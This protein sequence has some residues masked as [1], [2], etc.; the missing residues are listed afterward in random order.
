MAAQRKRL[1]ALQCKLAYERLIETKELATLTSTD[2][3]VKK[4]FYVRAK[5]IY[6]HYDEFRKAQEAV[7]EVI[8]TEEEFTEALAT[9]K[10]ADAAFYLSQSTFETLFPQYNISTKSEN[11]SQSSAETAV[12]RRRAVKLPDLHLPTFDGNL[13][14]WIA[15]LDM[16]NSS[17]HNDTFLTGAEKFQYLISSLSGTPLNLVNTLSITNDNYTI[18]YSMLVNR[19]N[20]KRALATE[21]L[22]AIRNAPSAVND[23]VQSLQSLIDTFSRNLAALKSLEFNV[24]QWDFL[25]FNIL[26][27]KLDMETKKSFE[28]SVATTEFPTYTELMKFLQENCSALASLTL[29]N[30]KVSH[31]NKPTAQLKSIKTHAATVSIK[32]CALCKEQHLLH[33][34]PRFLKLG[35]KERYQ[36]IKDLKLCVNCFNKNHILRDCSSK[37]NCRYCNQRHHSMLHFNSLYATTDNKEPTPGTSTTVLTNHSVNSQVLLATAIV[38]VEDASGKL[39]SCRC[40]LDS[41][42]QSNFVAESFVHK[43]NLSPVALQLAV[44]GIS[45][46]ALRVSNKVD[47]TLHS[48]YLN[49]QYNLQCLVLRTITSNLP[50]VS[51]N[52]EHIVIP[53]DVELADNKFN[54][55][56]KIDLLIG[57]P[58]FWEIMLSNKQLAGKSGPVLQETKLGWILSGFVPL[59]SIAHSVVSFHTISLAVSS[60]TEEIEYTHCDQELSN[61]T[62]VRFWQVEEPTLKNNSTLSIEEREAEVHFQNTV[63]RNSSGRFIVTIPF[64]PS[65]NQ[66]GNSQALARRRFFYLE[67]KLAKSNS[68]KQQYVDFM[69]EYIAL[70]HMSEVIDNNAL[71]SYYIPHHAVVKDS[72]STKLRVVFDASMK[73]DSGIS[74]NNAQLVGPVVQSDLLS[75]LLRFRTYS[76]V[77]TADIKMMYRQVLVVDNQRQYQRIF[78][79]ADPKEEL[80]TYQLNTVTYGTASGPFLATRCLKQ[81]ALDI[82]NSEPQVARVISKDFYV[83]DVLTGANSIEELIAIRKRVSEV[84]TSA[85]LDLRKF[86]SNN[87]QVLGDICESDTDLRTLEFNEHENCKTLG[88]IWNS[89]TDYIQYK[90]NDSNMMAA[91]P[92]KRSILSVISAIFDPLGLI[93]PVIVKAKLLIQALWQLQLGWDDVIPDSLQLDWLE[94]RNHLVHLN[95]IS[96]PRQAVLQNSISIELHGFCDASMA[97]YGS[98]IYLRATDDL[99]NISTRLL[100]AKSKVAPLKRITLP[101]LELCGAHLLVNLTTTVKQS[102]P[103]TQFSKFFYWCDSTIALAWIKSAPNRW[104]TFVC[105]R[106]ADIQDKTDISSW[107]HV[108]S[109]LNPADIVSRGIVPQALKNSTLWWSGPSFLSNPTVEIPVVDLDVINAP[110]AAKT[111]SMLCAAVVSVD[112]TKFEIFNR[113]SKY[114]TLV[115]VVAYALRWKNRVLN[116][117]EYKSQQLDTE[118]VEAARKSLIKLAQSQSFAEDIQCLSN[119]SQ[120]HAKSKILSLNPFLDDDKILR[121]GG[122]LRHSKLPFDTKHP[123]LICTKHKFSELILNEEHI[124]QLH[125]GPQALL[126]SIRNRYWPINGRTAARKIVRSCITCF[127]VKP[128]DSKPP[129]MGDLPNCRFTSNEVFNQVGVDYA[130]PFLLKP[131]RLR[132]KAGSAIKCYVALFVC[133]STKAL[134]LEV[135]SELS[136]NAFIAVFRR[137][138]SRRGKPSLVLSDNGTNFVGANNEL[139]QF[140]TSTANQAGIAGS[141]LHENIKWNFIPARS[142]NFG[143]IWEAGV[144]SVKHHLYRVMKNTSF[145]IEEFQTLLV[146]VE[147]ILNSRPLSP[148][149]VD[150][151]DFQ[152]LTP[153]HFLI[154][155]PLTNLPEEDYASVPSNRLNHYQQIQQ[156]KQNFWT[157]WSKE[158]VSELQ[159]RQ[160]W[161]Q[162]HESLLK[163]GSLV[164]IKE[165]N[166]PPLKWRL[167]RVAAIHPGPD[168]VVRVASLR[169]ANGEVK[170]AVTKLCVLPV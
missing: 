24:D 143:G 165:E 106:V 152:P 154:G 119:H 8:S 116:R 122:R 170:R 129:V 47:L 17:I 111:Q 113:F 97:A 40:L 42:S 35:P 6:D 127:R 99:S 48:N 13:K 74:L 158:Y 130:G 156:L 65:I 144:K 70:G 142:P 49:F 96:I 103:D 69:A 31:Q 162:N 52:R 76:F 72:V 133:L 27:D 60:P 25:L 62:L 153:A 75:I 100:I 57:A 159:V 95:A 66:I 43:L 41:G 105:N 88:V 102:M 155:R 90:I 169:T 147:A 67:N 168:G 93:S 23:S 136:T 50:T 146:Q 30:T 56:N 64:K 22:H 18:A 107:H 131:C 21:H 91:K 77:F 79:R 135:A 19:Y 34:C 12:I 98:C 110:E 39:H 59:T 15:Y 80:R 140:L 85:E 121:V 32:T 9:S 11:S 86:M 138:I 109:E 166:L 84:L 120:V 81:L 101:R 20:N 149:S 83:D 123:I 94:I 37:F 87:R 2:N 132:G 108:R 26:L 28:K 151:S 54:I 36:K 58:L 73:S 61:D 145:T 164:V 68:L 78:W 118:E 112:Q 125:C 16:F 160:K 38:K 157:R 150:P 134:H 137:F 115:N 139:S 82:E 1:V 126:Y 29:N 167:G 114:K 128:H 89:N 4:L 55:S 10:S 7:L 51:F 33:Q 3:T 5:Q 53:S 44:H 46:A 14:N 148:L 104:K 163:V 161:K 92:T 124:R 71:N 63:Y 141:F 45:Q 117:T